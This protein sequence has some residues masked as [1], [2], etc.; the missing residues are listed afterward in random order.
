MLPD[1]G[2]LPPKAVLPLH[3]TQAAPP[4][5]RKKVVVAKGKKPQVAV[6][7][8]ARELVGFTWAIAQAAAPDGTPPSRR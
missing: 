4:P 7:A 2:M 5:A 6:T 8:I 3:Q 1:I